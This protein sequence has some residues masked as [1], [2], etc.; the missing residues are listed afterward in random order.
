MR[1]HSGYPHFVV[2]GMGANPEWMLA[3][4][5]VIS[6]VIFALVCFWAL[7]FMDG[8]AGDMCWVAGGCKGQAFQK[9]NCCS[10]FFSG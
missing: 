4:A 5:S 1:V 9:K 6:A 10:L 7:G 3:Y 8:M 2:A